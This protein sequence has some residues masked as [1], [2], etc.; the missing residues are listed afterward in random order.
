MSTSHTVTI[1]I[2]EVRQH[3]SLLKSMLGAPA[4]TIRLEGDVLV[5]VLLVGEVW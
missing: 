2:N 1:L 5:I 3:P 4:T